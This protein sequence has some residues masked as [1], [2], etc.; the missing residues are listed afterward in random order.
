MA[1]LPGEP[2]TPHSE[3][4]DLRS[5]EELF[6]PDRPAR[7]PAELSAIM[8]HSM[9]ETDRPPE[10]QRQRDPDAPDVRWIREELGL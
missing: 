9:G 10:L 6:G 1:S 8:R 3:R 5:A 2:G 4:V 7:S